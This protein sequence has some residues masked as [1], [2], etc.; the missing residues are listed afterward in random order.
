MRLVHTDGLGRLDSEHLRR[1]LEE[2]RSRN[3]QPVFI[4]ATAGTTNAGMVDPLKECADIAREYGAWFHV[5]AAWGGAIRILPE[6]SSTLDG[7]ELADSITIDAHKWLS[8]PM[9]AGILLCKDNDLLGQ[10]FRVTASYMPEGLSSA[11]PLYP[12]NSMVP[13]FHWAQ[14][15]SGIGDSWMGGLSCPAS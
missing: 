7:V 8:V 4:G 12:L 14:V 11:G 3:H 13:P 10:T 6:L 1:L 15:V 9:G 5:D 2:D